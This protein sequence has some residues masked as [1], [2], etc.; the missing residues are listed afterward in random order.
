MA[1]MTPWVPISPL[2]LLQNDAAIRPDTINAR[3]QKLA[4]RRCRGQ[5][6]TATAIKGA[7]KYMITDSVVPMLA[8][9]PWL[10]KGS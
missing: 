10:A 9:P 8:L 7:M 6:W 2:T 1:Y 5:R 4:R 3:P